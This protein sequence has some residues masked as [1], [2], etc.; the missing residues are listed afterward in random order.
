MNVYYA[1]SGTGSYHESPRGNINSAWWCSAARMP[2]AAAV[3]SSNVICKGIEFQQ[4]IHSSGTPN[5]WGVWRESVVRI[6]SYV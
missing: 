3:W 6:M 5:T 4:G 2:I 1:L